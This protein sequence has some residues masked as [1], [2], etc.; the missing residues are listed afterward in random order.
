VHQRC[1]RVQALVQTMPRSRWQTLSMHAAMRQQGELLTLMP[2]IISS[3]PSSAACLQ[4]AGMLRGTHLYHLSGP[5]PVS[6][7]IKPLISSL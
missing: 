5:L 7:C 2:V 6:T 1:V 3:N 4:L